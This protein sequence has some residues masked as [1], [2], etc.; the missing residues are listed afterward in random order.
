MRVRTA[1]IW[2]RLTWSRNLSWKRVDPVPRDGGFS[3]THSAADARAAYMARHVKSTNR[4]LIITALW[5]AKLMP[6]I[7][8]G[9]CR[10]LSCSG[11]PSSCIRATEKV[12]HGVPAKTALAL[13]STI[14]SIM[15]LARRV[16]KTS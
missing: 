14:A 9:S 5:P 15:A 12:L 4:S 2:K 6:V 16:F 10:L 7:P 13:P 1:C 11:P 3:T 8:C